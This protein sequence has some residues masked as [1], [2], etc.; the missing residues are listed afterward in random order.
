[1]Y[2]IE[3]SLGLGTGGLRDESRCEDIVSEAL[4][5]GYRHIDTARHYQNERAIGRAIQQSK[6]T[7]EELFIATKVHSQNL[8]QKNI[9]QSVKKS[10]DALG[11]EQLDLVYIHWPSHPYEPEETLGT[12]SDLVSRGDIG[13]IGLSNFT[14]GGVQEA[15]RVTDTPIDAVQ[16]EMH[17]FLQQRQLK[18][19]TE[20]HDIRLVAHT[21]L[22][23]G[24]VLENG[25]IQEVAKKYDATPAQISLAWL[26]D[27]QNVAAVPSASRKHLRENLEVFDIEMDKKDLK[28]IGSLDMGYRC[29]DYEFSPW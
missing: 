9:R 23:Q 8:G 15:R 29:V 27:D 26:L 16:V 19:Y 17:P 18:Q 6:I 28:Q 21:P 7:E 24:K 20:T 5:L 13:G 25:T 1:M 14:P 2:D 3:F 22:C 4:S 10:L 12:L 11:V